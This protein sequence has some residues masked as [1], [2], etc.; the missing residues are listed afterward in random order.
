MASNVSKDVKDLC[1]HILDKK[2]QGAISLSKN[3][4]I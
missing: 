3:D 4:G 1:K 2:E